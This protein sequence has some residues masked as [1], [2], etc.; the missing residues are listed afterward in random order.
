MGYSYDLPDELFL[1]GMKADL[2]F[3][4]KGLPIP[5]IKK[6]YIMFEYRD[7]TGEEITRED[8]LEVYPGDAI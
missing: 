5:G 1:P 7:R 2:Q 6:K 4:L 8:I 3:Y